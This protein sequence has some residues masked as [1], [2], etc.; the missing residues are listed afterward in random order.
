MAANG[1]A[2]LGEVDRATQW[3]ALAQAMEP[4]DPMLLY[5]VGCIYA[6]DASKRDR[7]LDFLEAAVAGGLTQRGWFENDSNLD[8]LRSH[9]RFRALLERM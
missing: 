3:A 6:F 8:P 1:L 5:N 7:A 9:P 2:G 4:Q